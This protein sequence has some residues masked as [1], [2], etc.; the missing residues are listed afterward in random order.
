MVDFSE[1]YSQWE[2][3]ETIIPKKKMDNM[4]EIH[5]FLLTY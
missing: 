2:L 3:V 4:I 5:N 1:R